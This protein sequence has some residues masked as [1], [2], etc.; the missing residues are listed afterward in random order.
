MAALAR[1]AFHPNETE[2][3]FAT[4]S[5]LVE[6]LL[7]ELRHARFGIVWVLKALFQSAEMALYETQDDSRARLSGPVMIRVLSHI[8]GPSE[9]C[10]KQA[11][12]DDFQR[13]QPHTWAREPVW[14]FRTSPRFRWAETEVG[15]VGLE[16]RRAQ[17]CPWKAGPKNA[18]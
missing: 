14:C 18:L 4:K 3:R 11:E 9:S 5:E 13:R 1:L 8:R 7:D 2:F 17:C 10:A 15:R 6:L 16:H 12:M